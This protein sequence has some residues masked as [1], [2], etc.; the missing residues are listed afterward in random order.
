MTRILPLLPLALAS[1]LSMGA[2]ARA[3]DDASPVVAVT[4]K[5]LHSLVAG[6]MAGIGKPDLV[7]PATALPRDYAPTAGETERLA[8]ARLV[9]WIG[10][11]LER[12]FT[13]PLARISG[14]TGW[15]ADGGS[16]GWARGK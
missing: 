9:F 15:M 16:L 8:K 5:P 10:P 14:A 13:R 1:A 6:V 2:A 12:N 3:A 4:I 7:V 11:M